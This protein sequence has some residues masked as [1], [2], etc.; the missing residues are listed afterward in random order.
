MKKP[1]R[2]HCYKCIDATI[3][4]DSVNRHG[5]RVTTFIVTFPRIILAEVNTHR[6][7]SRNSASSRAVPFKKMVQRCKDHPFIPIAY[8]KDHKGMQGT[9]YFSTQ[10]SKMLDQAWLMARNEAV[11]AAERMNDYGATKQLCNR[12][13]EPF[14]YHTAIITA[15]AANLY[16]FGHYIIRGDILHP[17][18]ANVYDFQEDS[19][20]FTRH[21]DGR[22]PFPFFHVF[23]IRISC[24]VHIS[25]INVQLLSGV[26]KSFPNPKPIT[27][28]SVGA[29]RQK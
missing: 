7:F 28:L 21:E 2:K 25:R 23:P 16:P 11:D 18:N 17:L 10:E 1:L 24:P 29:R 22:L 4:A 19:G 26:L 20:R 12:L 14:M 13:L 6:M 27:R 9:E 8:Q 3:I 15:A 5:Q